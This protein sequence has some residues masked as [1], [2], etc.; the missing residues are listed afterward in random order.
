MSEQT[1]A[2]LD[3]ALA[4]HV[5]DECD[6]GILTGYITQ[7]QYTDMDLMEDG[8]TGYL[9]VQADN[10]IFTTSLG[11]TAYLHKQMEQAM[12]DD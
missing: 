8:S 1:K 7:A 11:L 6:G 4:A 2:A 5:A 9:R 3:A 12:L 10:Q